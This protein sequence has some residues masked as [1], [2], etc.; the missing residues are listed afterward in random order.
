[1]DT[2]NHDLEK[3][4]GLEWQFLVSI[5]FSGGVYILYMIFHIVYIYIH[6]Y[7]TVYIYTYVYYIYTNICCN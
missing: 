4:T 1:M 3:V 6:M 5:L 7:I 2:P